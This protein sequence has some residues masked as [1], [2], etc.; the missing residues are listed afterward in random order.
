MASYLYKTILYKPNA[1][2]ADPPEHNVANLADFTD[3]HKDNATSVDEV[4][5]SE[6]TF[7]VWIDYAVFDSYIDGEVIV[8]ADVKYID[9]HDN[10]VLNLLVITPL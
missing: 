5:L 10:L 1:T 4:L 9:D 3:N 2:V 8:W 6:T 7:V